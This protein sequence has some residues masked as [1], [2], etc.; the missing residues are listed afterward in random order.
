MMSMK[1]SRRRKTPELSLGGEREGRMLKAGSTAQPQARGSEHTGTS[2]EPR[3]LSVLDQQGPG[4]PDTL[5]VSDQM[6]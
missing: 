2:V 6:V 3:P 1:A 4:L 5:Q